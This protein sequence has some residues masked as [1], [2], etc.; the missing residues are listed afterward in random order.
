LHCLSWVGRNNGPH[1]SFGILSAC[2]LC[3][4]LHGGV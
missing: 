2:N 4:L 3:Y 1:L